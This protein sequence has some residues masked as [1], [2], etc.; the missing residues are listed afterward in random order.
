MKSMHMEVRGK[1]IIN[2]YYLNIIIVTKQPIC[3][4]RVNGKSVNGC[5]QIHQILY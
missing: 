2:N 1:S 3:V 4:K 5:I